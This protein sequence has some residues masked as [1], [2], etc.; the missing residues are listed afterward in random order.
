[1]DDKSGVPRRLYQER[2]QTILQTL[3]A[4]GIALPAL[5]SGMGKCGRCQVRF[6]GYA[7]L[8]TQVERGLIEPY[9]LRQGYRLACMARPVR[10][11]MVEGAW[12][13]A[14]QAETVAVS[15]LPSDEET[16]QEQ[17]AVRRSTEKGQTFIAA[18][19]GTTTIAMQLI[20]A[21][22]GTVL[23]T[24][25][26]MNPQSCYGTDVIARIQAAAQGQ[27]E[28][29][30][31]LLEEALRDG[32][33]RFREK[34][35][36]CRKQG[37]QVQL[38]HLLCIACNTT[39]GHMFLGYDTAGLGRKPFQPVTLETVRLLWEDME[40]VILPGIS[41]FVG[42]DAVAGL[43]ACGLCGRNQV[44][45]TGAAWLFLDLGTN[46]EMVM[47]IGRRMLCTA[48]A[49]GPAF[50]GR[51]ADGAVPTDRIAAIAQLLE[52]GL[53]DETG[54]LM[55]PYFS[56]G[57]NVQLQGRGREER[58]LVFITQEDIRQL[59]M[60][61]AAV[62]T[63]ISF[64][65]KKLGIRQFGQIGKVY[66][67]GGFGFYLDMKAAVRIGLLPEGSEA[68]QAVGNTSLAGAAL[69]GRRLA[70]GDDLQEAEIRGAEIFNL[71]EEAGFEQAYM[72]YMNFANIG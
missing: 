35:A 55:E 12:L 17:T 67:A 54:L 11:C 71:A 4:G 47:G 15:R 5:C 37:E 23:E 6:H 34:T 59:Q 41:A 20:A 43:Y 22:D 64:L 10:D 25:T 65:M 66:I 68:I 38:P 57:I 62:R 3:R 21:A 24:Y 30:R 72:E 31:R 44:K 13:P 52:Q 48:V 50:E 33:Y 14:P 29:L 42:G 45:E 53:A 8:P 51:G 58:R 32:I 2:G 69:L 40:T 61:K 16:G 7:P 18:D 26:C 49:A 27:E 9:R 70:A 56:D 28:L 46:A 36:Q 39:M 19:I 60:A 63:G 1:M